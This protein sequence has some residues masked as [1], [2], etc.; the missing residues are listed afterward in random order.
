MSDDS[1]SLPAVA[2]RFEDTSRTLDELTDRLRAITMA[3]E[4]ATR[5]YEHGAQAREQ[6]RQA[7]SCSHNHPLAPHPRRARL[8]APRSRARDGARPAA[9]ARSSSP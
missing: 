9:R 6:V 5:T 7:F 8:R 1:L 4:H 3:E 2:R